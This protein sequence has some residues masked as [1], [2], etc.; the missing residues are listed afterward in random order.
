[1]ETTTAWLNLAV[2]SATIVTLVGAMLAGFWR[3]VNKQT[4]AIVLEN[5]VPMAKY[6]EDQE[7]LEERLARA[8]RFDTEFAVLKNQVAHVQQDTTDIKRQVENL[9]GEITGAINRVW[10]MKGRMDR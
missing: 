7:R 6:L 10:E 5:A 2:N 3:F 8:E 9:S 4:K 1:M